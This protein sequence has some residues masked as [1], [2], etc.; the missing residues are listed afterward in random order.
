MLEDGHRRISKLNE[1]V[2]TLGDLFQIGESHE[3]ETR[4]LLLLLSSTPMMMTMMMR[5]HRA[6]PSSPNLAT[7]PAAVSLPEMLKNINLLEKK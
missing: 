1:I 7:F 3:D 5:R 6:V 4:C 2:A